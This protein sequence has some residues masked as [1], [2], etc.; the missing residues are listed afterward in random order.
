MTGSHALEGHFGLQAFVLADFVSI[1]GAVQRRVDV[2]LLDTRV[3]L[4]CLKMR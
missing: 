1:L 2:L 3:N 4:A